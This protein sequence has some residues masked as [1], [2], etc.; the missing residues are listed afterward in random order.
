MP[1]FKGPYVRALAVTIA[2]M[3]LYQ[4]VVVPAI[5][6]A[7]RE[8]T[9]RQ[10]AM[11]TLPTQ[12]Q[13]WSQLFPAEAWQNQRPR[14]VQTQRGILLSSKW[15]QLAPDR[16]Q[17][18]PLTMIIPQSGTKSANIKADSNQ[19]SDQDVWIVSA[20]KAEI[21]FS[22][23]F[24]WTSGQ[25]PPLIG[26]RLVGQIQI[27]RNS[28]NAAQK[29][30]S[31]TTRDV[32]IDRRRV[33]TVEPVRIQWDDS[34]IRGRDLSIFL[35]QDLLSQTADDT[36]PWGVL[37]HLELIYVDE[38]SVKL[39]DGGLWRNVKQPQASA[40]PD[41]KNLPARLQ[42]TS[43]GPFRFDFIASI[44]SLM[45]SVHVVHEL[46]QLPPDQFWSQ[47]LH[48][49]L[50]PQ[51]TNRPGTNLRP[52]QPAGAVNLGG[53]SLKQFTARGMDPVGPLTGET[54][55]RVEAPNIGANLRAK[56]VVAN[57]VEN[58]LELSGRLDAA[59]A[60]RTV[61]MLDYLGYIFRSPLIQYRS[62][63]DSKH[64]G[65]L[66][67]EGPG[68]LES[69]A[70]SSLGQCNIRWQEALHMKPD[71]D[72]QWI[73]LSGKT[74]VESRVHGFMTSDILDVWLKPNPAAKNKTQPAASS[75]STTQSQLAESD[76]L[77]DRMRATGNVNL[78]S[79]QVKAIVKE[80]H[81]WLVHH[82]QQTPPQD[83]TL[84]LTDASGNAAQQLVSPPS[85][86][87]PVQLPV[88]SGMAA[89][90]GEPISV[91][92]EQLQSRIIITPTQS[93][94]D[95]LTVN[96]P[97]KMY[98]QA[99]N[100]S[101]LT[102]WLIDGQQLTLTTNTAGQADA[103]I[104][105][106]PARISMGEAWLVGPEIRYD[107]K[108]GLIWMDKPGEFAVPVEAINA[109][110]K[111]IA[112]RPATP[113][114]PTVKWIKPPNCRWKGRLLFDGTAA[115]IEGD[116]ELTGVVAT[117]A[118]RFWHVD[119][120]C[121]R[122]DLYLKDPVD[123]TAPKSKTTAADL[124]RI[125]LSDAVDIRASQLNRQGELVS[126]ERIVVP[127][128]TYSLYNSQ[129]IGAGPGWLRSH[130]VVQGNNPRLT[131]AG[132]ALR[133]GTPRLQ[134]AHLL[135]RDSVVAS[136]GNKEVIFEGKVEVGVGPLQSW[137]DS[138]DLNT[139]QQLKTDEMLVGCDQLR[140][141]DT[142]DIAAAQNPGS[143]IPQLRSQGFLEAQAI[144]NVRFKGRTE[145][146]DFSGTGYRVTYVQAKDM[147]MLEGDGR[148][149]AFIE[150]LPVTKNPS[151][152]STRAQVISAAINVRTLEVQDLR[153]SSLQ[154]E[155]G[156]SNPSGTAPTQ[157]APPTVAP[158]PRK[159]VSDWLR[160][161]Q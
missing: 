61:A 27:T 149:P 119:G 65:W 3:L 59:G 67:A 42:V 13:W 115:R 80:L 94:V 34:L 81:L 48:V 113:N 83:N 106:S 72:D 88:G 74:F 160:Q 32:Q 44:A 131:S 19:L 140:C 29:P 154:T 51:A 31:L 141:Y 132:P 18:E 49:T 4:M 75:S 22:E 127:T 56:R 82:S 110:S 158:N 107:Q 89:P 146:G 12:V 2:V 71:G 151:E 144:G 134:G 114:S 60:V 57:L 33:W 26:G 105:G 156:Q 101:A 38:I 148:I 45:N 55:V 122:M 90:N 78:V 20:G 138:I 143:L 157:P 79:A 161:K 159:G 117:D 109:S 116:I 15:T 10:I 50:E 40:V 52:T 7:R 39:P 150:R 99:E 124:D 103:Q 46:A 86:T 47:E 43:G 36:S 96:G 25:T 139:M 73:S 24:D 70:Q 93:W 118:D 155:F 68:E 1:V 120:F 54:L 102:A 63:P 95:N 85:S 128:L 76:Y 6:P 129:I 91:E 41:T 111:N 92:G 64:L 108:S 112:P 135:F 11:E 121:Q 30:W 153:L 87:A 5:E 23:A 137:D 84:K 145:K 104:V 136:L 100:N 53:L 17:L 152:P 98:R 62:D 37:E 8:S 77:P 123:L 9:Q 28:K 14:V 126:R 97:L 147:V 133:S 35:K 58:Q 142:R 125:V 16:F 21:Q 66:A 69:P 130:H